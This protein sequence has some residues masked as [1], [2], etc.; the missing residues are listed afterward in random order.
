MKDI[1]YTLVRVK[2]CE[3]CGDEIIEA[4]PSKFCSVCY[5]KNDYKKEEES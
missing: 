2:C 3:D 4:I 1:P 5:W